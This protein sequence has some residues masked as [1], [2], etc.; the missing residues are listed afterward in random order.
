MNLRQKHVDFRH[1]MTQNMQLRS[2]KTKMNSMTKTSGQVLTIIDNRS[3]T[4]A[5]KADKSHVVIKMTPSVWS[6]I[7]GIMKI[8][9]C[10]RKY[11]AESTSDDL[12]RKLLMITTHL[13]IIV[14]PSTW[15]SI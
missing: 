11:L 2:K 9:Y 7:S 3:V 15:T 8:Y 1:N 14:A 13:N 4:E 10:N 5:K 6:L 12:S